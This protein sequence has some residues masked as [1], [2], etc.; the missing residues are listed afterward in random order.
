MSINYNHIRI[1]PFCSQLASVH[2]RN[3]VIYWLLVFASAHSRSHCILHDLILQMLERLA[4]TSGLICGVIGKRTL[5]GRS[6]QTAVRIHLCGSL[7]TSSV[8]AATQFLCTSKVNHGLWV[9]SLETFVRGVARAGYIESVKISAQ[10]FQY[11]F[12]VIG[13]VLRHILDVTVELR[14]TD[15]GIGPVPVTVD[16]V[17]PATLTVSELHQGFIRVTKGNAV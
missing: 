8:S 6:V 2:E 12:A 1:G 11:I 5:C 4:V 16:E 9:K 7:G 15:G 14:K 10:Y 3:T 13:H 17:V